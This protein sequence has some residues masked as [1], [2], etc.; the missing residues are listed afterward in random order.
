MPRE[1]SEGTKATELDADAQ[2]SGKA[3]YDTM[4]RVA[5][6]GVRCGPPIRIATL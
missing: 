3:R 4:Y 1:E 5:R 6:G 2:E